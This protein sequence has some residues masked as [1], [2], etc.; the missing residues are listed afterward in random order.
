MLRPASGMRYGGKE[1][2]I[3]ALAS[4]VKSIKS[5]AASSIRMRVLL[6]RILFPNR[7]RKYQVIHIS[8]ATTTP[9]PRNLVQ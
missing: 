7:S 2:T 8:V 6:R 5:K 9:T 4:A 3:K 1:S